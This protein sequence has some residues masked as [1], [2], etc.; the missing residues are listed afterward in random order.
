MTVAEAAR[1]LG[2]TV[3]GLHSRIRKGQVQVER[4]HPR[5]LL[6]PRP[7]VERLKRMGKLRPGP[8][9]GSRRRTASDSSDA[10]AAMR[11]GGEQSGETA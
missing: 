4:F 2:L 9:L 11:P 5:M 3:P 10:F 1:E 6:I 8:K 7:E